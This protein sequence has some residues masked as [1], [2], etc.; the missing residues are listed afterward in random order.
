[1]RT[2]DVRH[3]SSN[4]LIRAGQVHSL[5]PMRSKIRSGG[6]REYY[7]GI[8]PGDANILAL[9]LDRAYR[10]ARPISLPNDTA[11]LLAT[12]CVDVSVSSQAVT[13]PMLTNSWHPSPTTESPVRPFSPRHRKPVAIDRRDDVNYREEPGMQQIG[14]ARG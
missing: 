4:K 3:T 14:G 10:G 7:T 11:K 6:R 5:K 1:M 9:A 12:A 2:L 8:W 13:Q